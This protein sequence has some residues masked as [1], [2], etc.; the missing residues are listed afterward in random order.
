MIANTAAPARSPVVTPATAR[1]V[2]L[3]VPALRPVLV[4]AQRPGRSLVEHLPVP[5]VPARSGD[6]AR[7]RA[8][9]LPLA[10]PPPATAPAAVP[11]VIDVRPGAAT[12]HPIAAPR[13]IPEAAP[14][15]AP[16]PPKIDL[17]RLAEQVQRIL[18]R[19]T[20]HARARQGLPR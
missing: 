6:G 18:V 4:P 13:P 20:A 19:Q 12:P 8:V 5:V 2:P 15:P 14:P 7:A 11:A 17:P 16:P 3:P 10:H 9:E 1:Q